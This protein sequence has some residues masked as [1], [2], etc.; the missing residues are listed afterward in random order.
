MIIR[1]N[2]DL[3]NYDFRDSIRQHGPAVWQSL[4]SFSD[5]ART[6]GAMALSWGGLT[7]NLLILTIPKILQEHDCV[8]D[9]LPWYRD[10]GKIVFFTM[11]TARLI[12]G[13]I[14]Y[15]MN[16]SGRKVKLAEMENNT[17]PDGALTQQANEAKDYK[18]AQNIAKLNRTLQKQLHI[19]S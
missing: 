16:L 1:F 18:Y 10:I 19:F 4:K 9:K 11:I 8:V 3:R 12:W 13:V 14:A 5:Q 6:A 17:R 7:V 2:C 15:K